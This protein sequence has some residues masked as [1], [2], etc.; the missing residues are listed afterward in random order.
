MNNQT[1]IQCLLRNLIR[2]GIVNAVDLEHG[3]CRVE[4]GG[5]LTDWLHWLTCRAGCSRSWRALSVGE[6]LLILALGGELDTAFMLPGVFSDD[7]PARQ[8]RRMRC[9]LYSRMTRCYYRLRW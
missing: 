3:L 1:D 9:T 4:T 8:L 6:Q 2:I 7:F 5:N